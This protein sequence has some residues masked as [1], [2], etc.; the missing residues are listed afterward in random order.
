[1]KHENKL[2]KT[3]Q[4]VTPTKDM[5][6]NLDSFLEQVGEKPFEEIKK[7]D[8]KAKPTSIALYPDDLKKIQVLKRQVEDETGELS[9]SISAIFRVMIQTVTVDQKFLE[10]YKKIKI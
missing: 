10:T 4:K 7:P 1:M 5:G 3:L 8:G 9:A 2:M 6:K